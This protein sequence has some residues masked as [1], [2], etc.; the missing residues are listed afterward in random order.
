MPSMSA[1]ISRTWISPDACSRG[2]SICVMSPVTTIF[3]PNPLARLDGR[4]RQDDPPD[5]PLRE[6]GDRERH[7]EIRL[8]RACRPHRERHRPLANGV[9]VA[10]LVDGLRR[11]L[12]AAVTPDDV[13]EDVAYVFRLV[14]GR[15]HGADRV[16]SDLVTA[17]DELD[18]LLDDCARRDDVLVVA[19]ESEPIPAEGDRRAEPLSER[20]QHAVL[21]ARELGGDLVRDVQHLL[22]HETQSRPVASRP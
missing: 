10:L 6:R 8:A 13:L 15:E 5:G 18:E 12:L 7:R 3:E 4:A 20:V 16:R 14:E 2:R 1:R 21:H 9:D 17:L 22:W 11:D 19:V